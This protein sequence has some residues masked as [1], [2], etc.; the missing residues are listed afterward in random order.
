LQFALVDRIA[1]LHIAIMRYLRRFATIA[2]DPRS[3]LASAEMAVIAFVLIA[4]VAVAGGLGYQAHAANRANVETARGA[5][6]Q[7]SSVAAWQF[8][9][10]AQREMQLAADA[11][12]GSRVQRAIRAP[13]RIRGQLLT[14]ADLR[15]AVG[16]TDCNCQPPLTV[17]TF[18]RWDVGAKDIVAEG[19]WPEEDRRRLAARFATE[20]RDPRDR[21][22]A[23]ERAGSAIHLPSDTLVTRWLHAGCDLLFDVDASGAPRLLAVVAQYDADHALRALYGAVVRLSDIRSVFVRAL[24]RESLLP[25]ALLSRSAQDSAIALDVVVGTK[26][27]FARGPLNTADFVAADS[28]GTATF[29]ALVRVGLE[30]ATAERLLI[31]GLPRSR[32]PLIGLFLGLTLALLAIALRQMRRTSELTRLRSDFVASVSH[33]LRTPLSLIRVYTETLIDE[34]SARPGH[35]S[36]FLGVILKESNRLSRL[37]E[38]LL[39]FADLERRTMSVSM[40]PADLGPILAAT[41]DDF[42]PLAESNAIQLEDDLESGVVAAVDAAAFRQMIFNLLTNAVKFSPSGGRVA[43]GLRRVADQA[44][45]TIDD[46]GPGIPTAHRRRVFERYVRLA[47]VSAGGA[48]GSGIGLAIVREL[49]HAQRMSVWID[50]SPL[51]GARVVLSAPIA[52]AVVAADTVDAATTAPVGTTA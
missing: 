14:P 35:R 52:D 10:S 5:L 15:A 4:I 47:D 11:T 51:G 17:Q 22:L 8:T 28:L 50:D 42:R 3:V 20:A 31:G 30:R 25:T 34:D 44:R 41:V 33:E 37:V 29:G 12:I 6:T 45:I 9:R 7:Y 36:H 46:Q 21:Q 38:N 26:K 48:A 49:A 24:N 18:F 1:V 40:A 19:N 32:L 2:R 16:S 43:V 13:E 23:A 27:V 39:R